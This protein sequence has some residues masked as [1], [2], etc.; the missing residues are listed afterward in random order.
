[1]WKVYVYGMDL[2]D[3]ESIGGW[4]LYLKTSNREEARYTFELLETAHGD[5]VALFCPEE[6]IDD[7][8][9]DRGFDISSNYP[10]DNYGMSAC[11]TA[12]SRYYQCQA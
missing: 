11:S 1:M 7:F 8:D 2:A 9:M 6:D 10:C 5:N 12:C 3:T 4:Q